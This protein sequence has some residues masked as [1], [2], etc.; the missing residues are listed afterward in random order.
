MRAIW[1][2]NDVQIQQARNFRSNEFYGGLWATFNLDGLLK[3]SDDLIKGDKED[4][5]STPNV[6]VEAG[7]K[8]LKATNQYSNIENIKLIWYIDKWVFEIL[9]L[10]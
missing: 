1:V 7:E 10:K 5:R 9:K 4:N 3:W 2:K 8:F 6:E